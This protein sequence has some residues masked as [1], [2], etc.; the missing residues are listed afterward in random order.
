M[1]YKVTMRMY[2]EYGI[3][4]EIETFKQGKKETIK[5]ILL[6]LMDDGVIDS[7]LRIDSQAMRLVEQSIEFK[8]GE[9]SMNDKQGEI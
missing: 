8:N 3:L 1:D 6:S 9:L 2:N 4:E 7:V 5:F